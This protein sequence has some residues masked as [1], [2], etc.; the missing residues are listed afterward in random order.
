MMQSDMTAI[1]MRCAAG[2][3]IINLAACNLLTVMPDSPAQAKST[4]QF[5]SASQSV[6]PPQAM[7]NV[8]RAIEAQ[9][10]RIIRLLQ[11]RQFVALANEV[12]P[13]QGL[14]FSPSVYLNPQDLKFSAVQVAKLGQNQTVYTW[15]NFDGSGEPIQLRF[16]DYYRRFLINR[17]FSPAT[18]VTY[19][20]HIQRGNSLNNIKAIYPDSIT[21]EY[22]QPAPDAQPMD[23]SS[24]ILV[25]VPSEGTYKLVAL[26]HDQ[27]T[28]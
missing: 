14:R 19:N 6:S 24:L 23:W 12:H 8:Q 5:V 20:K 3:S 22:H 13:I 18:Q 16:S 4:P 21:V 1:L 9:S 25:F 27:W 11:A 28:I 26:V 17:P 7:P 2:L 10:Q 15:G